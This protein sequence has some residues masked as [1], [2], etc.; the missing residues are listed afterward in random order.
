MTVMGIFL[1]TVAIWAAGAFGFLFGAMFSIARYSD[2][3]DEE[4]RRR[5]KTQKWLDQFVRRRV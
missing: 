4:L 1:V 3:Q 5:E 2:D